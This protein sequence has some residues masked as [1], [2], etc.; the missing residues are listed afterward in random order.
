MPASRSRLLRRASVAALAVVASVALTQ[1]GRP[2]FAVSADI[3][4]SQAYGGGGNTGAPYRADFIELYNRG[5]T[6]VPV[7]GWTVQYASATGSSWSKTALTGSIAPGH[8]YLVQEAAGTVGAA[9]PAPDATG[10]LAMSATAGKIALVTNATA[11]TCATGCATAAGVRDFLGYGTTASSAEGSPTG[12]LSN[13]TAALRAGG[14]ATDTDH[15]STDF[16]LAA[17][18]PRNS[19]GGVRIHDIQGAAH[20]SPMSGQAVA[21]VP[22]V[23]T[24][25][26][27]TGFFMQDP[28]PDA[29]PATSE[30]IFVFTTTAPGRTA[31]DSVT[32]SGTVGEFR[33]G[34]AASANL[35]TTEIDAPTVTLVT[36]GATLPAATLVGTGGRVP[37]ASV[38]DSGTTTGNAETSGTF[39]PTA[40]GLDFW[41][42]LEGMRVQLT[43]AAVVGP[44]TSGGDFP[45]VPA[46]STVRSARGGVVAQSTD[47]NPERVFVNNALKP[48]PTVNVGDTLTGATVG[49]LTYNSGNYQL[50]VTATPTA[51][52]GGIAPEITAA[53]T[54]T[55]LAVATFNVENLAPT[56]PA[57]KFSRL[58]GIV[59]TNL[60]APDLIAVE[61]VQD[62]SGAT[63]DGTVAATTTLAK[64]IAAIT[65][66]GGPTY[67]FR[68]ID[69][70]NDADGGQPGGNI[71]QVFLYRTDRG[72]A[73]VDRAGGTST[74]SDSVITVAGKPVLNFSPG[75]IDPANTAW[76]ASRK[77]LAGQFTF[78][79]HT[80]FAIANHFDAKLGDDPLMGRFQPINQPSAVQR[81]AQATEVHAFVNQI[82]AVDAAAD[83]V[84]LG[85]LNDYEYSSAVTTLTGGGALTDLPA[86]LPVAERYT[87]VFEGNSEVLDHILLSAN[88]AATAYGYDVVHVNS[89]FAD[90]ASDHEPQV[91]RIPLP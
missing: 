11:L 74:A 67:Q 34:G 42:S 86:T 76:N 69:P 88:L 68:E 32:V 84:V 78:N 48:T 85:D 90:Q 89:E 64:L 10:T 33:S 41:E 44:S 9:L 38:I 19:T 5:A 79:G 49:V 20:L 60:K 39:D 56:D 83:I 25:V 15:N 17:P 7:T 45:V 72:L 8:H 23:V 3:T 46:G 73:F 71:R 28:T 58:A 27:T 82:L 52:S 55:Q 24:A 51:T 81:V 14:G 1:T 16:A 2:A 29:D 80:V 26:T 12:N 18:N 65:A 4:I 66:A 31:G 57:T 40:H 54:A 36:T 21:G 53:P 62:N 87:Y 13:T 30:G 75:R 70:V 37:P 47:L 63:D 6:S 91:V 61:E 35:T 22:G 43:N 50:D 77:P 59:V